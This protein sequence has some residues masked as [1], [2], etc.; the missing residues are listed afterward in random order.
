VGIDVRCI[1]MGMAASVGLACGG[2]GAL[3]EVGSSEDETGPTMTASPLSTSSGGQVTGGFTDT[4]E[5]PLNSSSSPTT[6]SNSSTGGAPDT[7]PGTPCVTW[8]D[9]CDADSKCTPYWLDAQHNLPD[10]MG[11]LPLH[12]HPDMLGEPCEPVEKEAPTTADSCERGLGC[13]GGECIPLCQG[14]DM[15]CP[16]G[17]VCIQMVYKFAI[18]IARCDPLGSDCDEADSCL[19]SYYFPY[20]GDVIYFFEC[21][22]GLDTPLFELCDFGFECADGTICSSGTVAAECDD[23]QSCCNELCD[24]G[25]PNACQGVGQECIPYYD[26]PSPYPE[27]AELGYCSI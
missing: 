2:K 9:Q 25:A 4:G 15:T 8:D 11:C 13:W 1:L 17:A 6:T 24:L 5:L 7:P 23:R 22:L 12:P 27:Y 16:E 14:M 18:C 10:T 21:A 19:P 26:P 20:R 3:P